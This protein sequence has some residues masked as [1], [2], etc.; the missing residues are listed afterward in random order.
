MH[1]SYLEIERV[2][3]AALETYSNVHRGSGHHA[4]TS[5]RLY[6]QAKDV[7]LDCLGLGRKSHVV[8]FCSPRRATKLAEMLPLGAYLVVSSRELDLPFGIRAVVVKRKALPSGIPFE[9]GGGTAR[10]I[11]AD[12]VIWAN[13]AERFEAGTPAIVNAIT[14][15]RALQLRHTG[16]AFTSSAAP[17]ADDADPPE[18][19]AGRDLLTRLRQTIIGGSVPVP[20]A[21][22]PRSYVNLDNA[23]STPTFEPVWR[24]VRRAWRASPSQRQSIVSKAKEI[25]ARF[26]N[27]PLA[28]YDL[29]FTSNTTEAI[30]VVATNVGRADAGLRDSVLPVVLGSYLEHNSNELPWRGIAG[31][32][33]VRVSVDL[34][35]AIDLA[36]VEATL[37]AYNQEHAHGR[38]RITLVAV[39]GASNVLGVFPP[40]AEIARLAHAYGAQILVDA[41]QLAAHRRID[42]DAWGIDYLAFSGHKVYAP[43]GTGV[44]VAR[45]GFLSYSTA[46]LDAISASGEENIGGIAALT[47]ALELVER[48]GFDVIHEDEQILLK[49]TLAGLSQLPRVRVHGTRDPA[50]PRVGQK[51][52][53]VIFDV[54]RMLPSRVARELAERAGVGVR[55]GCHCAHLV[56]KR[57]LKIPRWA[58]RLQ[59]LMLR[60]APAMSLPGVV[61]VSFG[62]QTTVSDVDIFLDALKQI[63]DGPDKKSIRPEL[64]AFADAKS[65][66]VFAPPA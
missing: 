3:R 47:C 48:I 31:G 55:S 2:A 23:A 51:S 13:G 16:A 7:V 22:G 32:S 41:A 18:G 28:A 54:R 8:I 9:T 65:L 14:L 34:E 24:A 10:L 46:D 20:T 64:D 58:E 15:A 50:S 38:Q 12:W 33:L 59:Y 40:L 21:S 27:A 52:G 37:Q 17:V 60:V 53:I 45:K 1:E 19:L 63:C 44:L 5:S 35:G 25:C 29:V 39:S 56:I 57:L 11:S 43:F 26:V 61:R 6:D 49:R 4:V 30:N 66:A 42:M 36:E 62:L